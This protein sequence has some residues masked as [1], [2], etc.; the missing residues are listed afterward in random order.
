MRK[1]IQ[2]T[3]HATHIMD[4][5]SAFR[6]ITRTSLLEAAVKDDRILLEQVLSAT[7][8]SSQNQAEL[9][10]ALLGACLHG[11]TACVS[12]LLGNGAE[13]NCVDEND[14]TPLM[15]AAVDG[16]DGK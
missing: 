15:L 3:E 12:L 9:N 8:S 14:N 11:N 1:H 5:V 6:H 10:K 16:A 4:T 7:A 2:Q 13:V